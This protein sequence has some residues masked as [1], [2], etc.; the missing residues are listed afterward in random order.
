MPRSVDENFNGPTVTAHTASSRAILDALS[1]DAGYGKQS[2]TFYGITEAGFNFVDTQCNDYFQRLYKLEHGRDA[3]KQTLGAFGQTTNAILGATGATSLSI[4]V[5]AQAF[6]LGQNLADIY[7]DTFL[8]SLPAS[9]TEQFVSKIMT[10]Y[11]NAAGA[12]RGD[13]DS[14]PAA[15]REIQGYLNLCV[16]VTIEAMLTDHIADAS[17]AAVYGSGDIEIVTGSRTSALDKA[18]DQER[19]ITVNTAPIKNTRSRVPNPPSPRTRNALN[20]DEEG[21][22]PSTLRAIQA[23]VCVTPT[24]SW[25]GATREAISKLFTAVGD[26]RPRI[27]TSGYTRFEMPLLQR[28]LVSSLKCGKGQKNKFNI[29]YE[30]VDDLAKT[31]K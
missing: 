29:E 17:A 11:R 19:A 6:G 4:A 3:T 13:I 27:T 7:A 12:H 21:V 1:V 23:M 22:L 8:F 2:A 10:A 25:D 9:K 24:G 31:L 14:G 30:T 15:F 20:E 18:T 16:P 26:P 5:V 28:G